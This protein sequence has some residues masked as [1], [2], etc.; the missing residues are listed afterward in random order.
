[1]NEVVNIF[2]VLVDKFI[3]WVDRLFDFFGV[4]TANYS[5]YLVYA[6]LLFVGAKIFK[7]KLDFKTGK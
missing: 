1:M 2:S 6:L 4:Y 5:K 7:V 3:S